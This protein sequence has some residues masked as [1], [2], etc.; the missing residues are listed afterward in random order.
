[1]VMCFYIFKVQFCAKLFEFLAQR[2]SL[3]FKIQSAK[4]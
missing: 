1:M 3:V 2:K 4:V